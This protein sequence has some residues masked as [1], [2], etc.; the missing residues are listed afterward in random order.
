[1]TDWTA[2]LHP[3]A[4]GMPPMQQPATITPQQGGYKLSQPPAKVKAPPPLK[5]PKPA[6]PFKPAKP[7]KAPAA[8]KQPAQKG[9]SVNRQA[10]GGTDWSDTRDRPETFFKRYYQSN[11]DATLAEAAAAYYTSIGKDPHKLTGALAGYEKGASDQPED[12]EKL[13][14]VDRR[15]VTLES[16]RFVAANRDTW[17]DSHELAVRAHNHAAV[18]TSTFTRQRS[19]AVCEAFVR[20]VTKLGAAQYRPA[21]RRTA[22]APNTNFPDS[23]M[24]L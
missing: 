15:W 24:F 16:A 6:V 22:S 9:A 20:Q 17:D 19:A 1:M 18:K 13:S 2:A 3:T 7:V 10:S 5:Q 12:F 8:Q 21:P 11:P 4:A 14:G 23:L